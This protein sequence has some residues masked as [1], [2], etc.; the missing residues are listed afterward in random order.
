MDTSTAGRSTQARPEDTDEL[1]TTADILGQLPHD[2]RD[3]DAGASLDMLT[4]HAVA[5]LPSATGPAS[6]L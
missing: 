2:T 5:L 4:K 3:R 1:R 6:P